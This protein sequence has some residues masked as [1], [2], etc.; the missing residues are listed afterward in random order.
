MNNASLMMKSQQPSVDSFYKVGKQKRKS[1]INT[2]MSSQ[3]MSGVEHGSRATNKRNSVLF[4]PDVKP[5]VNTQKYSTNEKKRKSSKRRG[6]KRFNQTSLVRNKDYR[7]IGEDDT[8]NPYLFTERALDTEQSPLRRNK[9]TN[10]P[11]SDIK[12]IEIDVGKDITPPWF[13]LRSIE[14]SFRS[15][16]SL[17][18]EA[19]KNYFVFLE[20]LK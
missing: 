15:S 14:S 12:T 19:M 5:N 3:Y 6:G 8:V 2:S 20:F 7:C 18:R 10:D 13:S 17:L 9:S 4:S 11:Y 16:Q 1:E